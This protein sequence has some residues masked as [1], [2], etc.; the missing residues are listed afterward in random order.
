MVHDTLNNVMYTNV[1]TKIL[2][3]KETKDYKLKYNTMELRV[4]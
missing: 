2:T 3:K 4:V 1:S